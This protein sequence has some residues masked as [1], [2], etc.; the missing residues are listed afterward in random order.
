MTGISFAATA[1]IRDSLRNRFGKHPTIMKRVVSETLARLSVDSPLHLSIVHWE[2]QSS[3]HLLLRVVVEIY[4]RHRRE[5]TDLN[6]LAS[7]VG[8]TL[9]RYVFLHLDAEGVHAACGSRKSGHVFYVP[10]NV[11]ASQRFV[12]LREESEAN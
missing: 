8:R 9:M 2:E 10:P 11:A 1:F 6:A 7:I 12:Q 4:V 3:E 5:Q